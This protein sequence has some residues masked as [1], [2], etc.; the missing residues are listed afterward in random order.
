MREHALISG[1]NCGDYPPN[2]EKLGSY[3]FVDYY[4]HDRKKITI[5][6]FTESP[7]PCSNPPISSP[8]AIYGGVSAIVVDLG[9]PTCKA[10]YVGEDAPKAV[11]PSVK[12]TPFSPELGVIVV[13]AVAMD[14][15]VDSS[16]TNSNSEDPK[17]EKGR[18]LVDNIWEH[19]FRSCLI[20]D[21]KEHPMLLAEPPLNTQQA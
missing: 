10:S 21:P 16:K 1:L 2:Y 6:D 8:A 20:I 17:S 11:F 5:S 19:A 15:E 4:F 18:D 7:V 9:L 13:G 3:K 12:L 14:V